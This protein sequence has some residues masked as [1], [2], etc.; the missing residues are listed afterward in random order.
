MS[1]L[2]PELETKIRNLIQTAKPTKK[3]EDQIVSDWTE[4]FKTMNLAPGKQSTEF[5]SILRMRL[6]SGKIS[7]IAPN[8][9][10]PLGEFWNDK[11][12]PVL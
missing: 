10:D 3:Q 6:M 12:V 8:A 1:E 7:I 2:P 9:P 11:T 5:H 4:Y